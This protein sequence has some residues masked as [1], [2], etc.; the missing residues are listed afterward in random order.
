VYPR[1][2]HA[3]GI[4]VATPLAVYIERMVRPRKDAQEVKS[5]WLKVRTTAEQLEGFQEAAR[6]AG[7]LDGEIEFSQWVR[8]TLEAE[9]RRL[10]ERAQ[11]R[12]KGAR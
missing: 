4:F 1:E 10:L 5:A 8:R 2:T 3:Q 11:P 6:L 7:E 12:R 9:R